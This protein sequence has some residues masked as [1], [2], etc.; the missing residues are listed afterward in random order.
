M[1]RPR[2]VNPSSTAT[3][4]ADPA[5]HQTCDPRQPQPLLVDERNARHLLGGICAKSMYNF[6]QRGLL[7]CVKVGSRTLYD[8]RDLQSFVERMKQLGNEPQS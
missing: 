5:G 2:L 4:G 8:V 7:R 1:N 3:A 6:R